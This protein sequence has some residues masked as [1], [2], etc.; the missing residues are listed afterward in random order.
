LLSIVT[1]IL[2][3]SSTIFSGGLLSQ[4]E[5]SRPLAFSH[6]ETIV[7]NV[8]YNWGILWIPVGEVLFNVKEKDTHFEFSVNG[9][10]Y[11]SYDTVFKVRDNYVSRVGKND[12]LPINFRRD[13]LEGKYQR[14]D[15]IYFDRGGLDIYEYFGKAK[16]KVEQFIFKLDSTVLDMVGAIYYLRSQS[17]ESLRKGDVLKFRIFFDKELFEMDIVYH[18]EKYKKIKGIGNVNT[19]HFQIELISGYVFKKGDVM[20]VWLSVDKNNIPLLVESPISY[21]SVKAIIKSVSESTYAFDYFY[22]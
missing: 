14:Y 10:S 7:Y 12:L 1:G 6:D 21:G 2:F 8:Y 11:P 15:S 4:A 13:I 22:D 20:D 19:R 16:D 5:L 18:G 3:F 9:K 17:I